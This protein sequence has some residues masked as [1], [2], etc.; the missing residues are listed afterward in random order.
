MAAVSLLILVLTAVLLAASSSSS[1]Q[2]GAQMVSLS[3]SQSDHYRITADVLNEGGEPADSANYKLR[4]DSIGEAIEVG[5]SSSNNYKLYT[6]AIYALYPGLCMTIFGDFDCD[7]EVTVADIMQVASRWRCRCGDAC[8]DPLYDLDDD[9]DID[10][11]DIMLVAGQWGDTCGGTA[12]SVAPSPDR[13]E[14]EASPQSPTVRLDPADSTVE[15]GNT[16]TVTVMIDEASDLGAFQFDMHYAPTI[17]QVEAMTL[18]NLLA[19]TGRTVVPAGP[20][21]DNST[22]FASFGA[23]SFGSEPGPGGRGTLALVRLRV[24]G[25]GSSALDL[26]E[27]QVTDTRANSQ[28]PTVEDGTVVVGDG[29]EHRIYL[30]HL[31]KNRYVQ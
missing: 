18:G 17:V 25:L 3:S 15:V 20:S 13:S 8:Y 1:A 7:C 24:V 14:A 12:A 2:D 26:Q 23:F 6:G 4:P 27:V 9:C 5:P 30:P 22:G 29:G 21:V 10:I 31:S 11:V 16:F 28:A 19:S